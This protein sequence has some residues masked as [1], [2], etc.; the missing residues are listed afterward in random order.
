MVFISNEKIQKYALD[1]LKICQPDLFPSI[2]I[3]ILLKM[4][5][6]LP[7]TTASAESSFSTFGRLKLTYQINVEISD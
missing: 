5:C 4:L 2:Y 1:A 7:I 6:I 3:Y